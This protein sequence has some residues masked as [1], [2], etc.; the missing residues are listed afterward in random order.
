MALF[1]DKLD[2]R[3]F[4]STYRPLRLASL[5]VWA[6]GNE[7]REIFSKLKCSDRS[8]AAANFRSFP[9]P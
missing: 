4:A 6:L 3:E 8:A 2:A 7:V 1:V 9:K 5:G